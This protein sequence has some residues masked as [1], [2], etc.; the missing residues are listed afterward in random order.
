MDDTALPLPPA[1]TMAKMLGVPLFR[2]DLHL[3][4][5]PDG[6]IGPWRVDH[7]AMHT[8][9]G[10]WGT[11]YVMADMAILLRRRDEG[12]DAWMS[13]SP[14]ELESQELGCRHAYG[15][16][17]VMGL[18]MA[19]IAINAALNPA[20]ERVTVIERDDDVI[21]LMKQS[22]VLERAPDD[23]GRKITIV[24]GDALAWR[25]KDKVDFL[26]ADI[27]LHLAEPQVLDD[28]RRMQDNVAAEII[29]F[30]GQ[31]LVIRE[32]AA[33]LAPGQ[34][35]D[36]A[37]LRRTVDES[38]ALPLLIPEGLDYPALIREAAPNR[39]VR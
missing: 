9:M 25:P 22:G 19:W 13:M 5:Y 15:H 3:P 26:Y 27:W 7:C 31:E 17:V 14:Y 23:A 38:I 4:D 32:R 11:P 8:G 18:G 28:L 12:W 24:R 34:E 21:D 6:E 29:Y 36:D 2:T 16:T 33:V 37:L 10:F 30:W 39:R 1:E 35:L 20:V